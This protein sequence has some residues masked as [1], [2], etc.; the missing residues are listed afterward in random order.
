MSRNLNGA[1]GAPMPNRRVL[2]VGDYPIGYA[3]GIGETFANLV[4]DL[5]DAS[6]FQCHPAHLQPLDGKGVGT[7]STFTWPR[8]PA[9]WPDWASQM[10]RPLLK[11]RQATAQT[12][13]FEIA[14]AAI[15][16]HQIDAVIAYPVTPWVLFA[17]VR[18]RR[19]FPDVRFV[20]YVMDDWEGHHT[21]FG[22]PFTARRRAALNE[23]VATSDARFAC[24]HLMKRD[25]QQRFSNAWDVL[26]KG[27]DVA[28]LPAG[29]PFR[30]SNI[31]YTGAMN[32]FR[33]DAV[34]AFAEGLR[35]YR[36]SSGR[37][38][39][40]TMLGPTPDREYSSALARYG[41]IR[42]EPWVDNAAC[43]RRMA[44][45]DV[46]YLPLS[47]E[48]KLERIANLA[49][50]TKFP[51]YL[52]SGRPTI[53]HV[54]RESEV[55]QLAEG[56]GLPLTITSVDPQATCDL[57]TRMDRGAFD[58][59]DYQLRAQ[60]LL[61]AEFDQSVLRRRLATALWPP[62]NGVES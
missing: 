40:L 12:R 50:P 59:A 58:V 30:F 43:Q 46:L 19:A 33:F 42:T 9:S 27:V 53:F 4:A 55:H 51:E 20:F 13:L 62:A 10:Y 18:L 56:E 21:C 24:S 8:R 6:I 61:R 32:M 31:L 29:Q 41:F 44:T 36:E 16:R 47:F 14:S 49:M 1:G 7:A 38:V 54:P 60:R 35:R 5:P 25:Y 17:V 45:A 3:N 23:M 39:T 26:H 57:L 22:L 52:A 48:P 34:L 37:D 15:R 28:A 2:V 11:L